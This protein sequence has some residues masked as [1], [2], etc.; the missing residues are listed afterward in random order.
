MLL[1]AQS[2][3]V[4]YSFLDLQ[5]KYHSTLQDKVKLQRHVQSLQDKLSNIQMQQVR[6]QKV[7]P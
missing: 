2:K 3:D 7:A 4:L 6:S 5:G 1:Y